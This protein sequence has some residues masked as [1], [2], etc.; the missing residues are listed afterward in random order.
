MQFSIQGPKISQSLSHTHLE[1]S[2]QSDNHWN[3]HMH[4]IHDKASKRLNFLRMLITQHVTIYNAWIRPI[5][6]YKDV[7]WNNCSIKDS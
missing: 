7:V 2:F 3:K 4:P 1:I 5:L 6:E